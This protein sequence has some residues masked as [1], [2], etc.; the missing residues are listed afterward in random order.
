VNNI[1]KYRVELL[2]TVEEDSVT[3]TD[4]IEEVLS[5]HLVDGVESVE[6]VSMNRVLVFK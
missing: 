1:K 2:F 3:D 6:L 4:W 5:E